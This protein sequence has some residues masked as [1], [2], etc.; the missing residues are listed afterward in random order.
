MA[1]VIQAA[2]TSAHVFPLAALP[3]FAEKPHL[4]LH[5]S[6]ST[7]RPGATIAISN[8]VTGIGECVYDSGTR[9]CCT[10][11][12]RDQ[13]SCLDD[14]KA[15]M[16]STAQE[17]FT[18]SDR[19]LVDQSAAR[20]NSWNLYSYVRN[21]PLSNIDPSGNLACYVDGFETDCGQASQMSHAG[22]AEQCPSN[23]CQT[24]NQYGVLTRYVST[25]EGS[26]YTPMLS[27]AYSTLTAAGIAAVGSTN[28]LPITRR[29]EL[30]GKIYQ[31]P[32]G[33]YSWTLPVWG[34]TTSFNVGSVTT[35]DDTV[36]VGAYHTHPAY[37]TLDSEIFSQLNCQP[38]LLCDT[39]F[40]QVYW[41]VMFLGTPEGRIEQ[42]DPS[43]ATNEPLGCVLVG[44]PTFGRVDAGGGYNRGITV[45]RCK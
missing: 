42:F 37:A 44:T 41:K 39:G 28:P 30:G 35:P 18:S 26:Y 3:L 14:F 24:T 15:R 27:G 34:E 13:E 45:N 36:W 1:A 11:Q 38:G 33:K 4:G 8:T 9:P 12:Y 20:P 6:I 7:F 21:N 2:K 29:R 43:N 17:R 19:A 23:L 22:A 40:A 16:L 10:G 31:M 32:N 5:A 25:L